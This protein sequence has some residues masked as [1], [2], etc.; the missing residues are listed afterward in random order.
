MCSSDLQR[1]RKA[2][3]VALDARHAVALA[4][5]IGVVGEG[6]RQTADNLIEQLL[7]SGV[8]HVG[9]V[10][11]GCPGD[12]VRHWDEVLDEQD[13]VND[14]QRVRAARDCPDLSAKIGVVPVY[15]RLGAKPVVWYLS[16]VHIEEELL[17][18]GDATELESL[19][20]LLDQGIHGSV[21]RE[22]GLCVGV[23]VSTR[24]NS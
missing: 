15:L 6:R 18:P 11:L 8:V 2:D 5:V 3:L 23:A 1:R 24:D 19:P 14:T 7:A 21:A 16:G 9:K 13:G 10:E 4:R 12:Q 17:A 22:D 20:R